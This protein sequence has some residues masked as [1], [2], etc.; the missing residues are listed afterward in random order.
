MV[1]GSNPWAYAYAGHQFGSFAGQLGDGRAISLGE[2]VNTRGRR[3]E[4]QLK[5]AGMTPYSRFADGYA[6]LRS[7]IREFLCSEAMFHLGI[8]TT[9]A[10]ALIGS[11]RIVQREQD[12]SGAIVCRL[13]PSWIRLG[14]FE[15]FY[16]TGDSENLQ[17]LADYAIT[18]HFPE[19]QPPDGSVDGPQTGKY[20][21]LLER[22]VAKTAE[23][24]AHWQAYGVM[25]TDNFSILGLTIDYGPFQFLDG[26]DPDYV[27]NKSDFTGMY[28][29]SEQPEVGLRNMVKFATAIS[30]LIIQECGG[31]REK[32][33]GELRPALNQYSSILSDRYGRLMAKKIGLATYKETDLQDVIYPLLTI[34]A[35]EAVDYTLFFRS[36]SQF[37]IAS[38]DALYPTEACSRT[39][40]TEPRLIIAQAKPS[41]GAALQPWLE[42]YRKRLLEDISGPDESCPLVTASREAE[43]RKQMDSIN[44]RYILR[45]HLAQTVIEAAEVGNYAEVNELLNVLSRPFEDGSIQEQ[46]RWGGAV[47]DWAAGVK[48][49][50]SS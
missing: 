32:A 42:I 39:G 37:S 18:M 46:E 23:M 50:C 31:D 19:I 1:P 14:N 40:P 34:I 17:K 38:T 3:W 15:L 22:V 10:L 29:F 20:T 49:S 6:V 35:K 8:P 44:P 26:Y 9:R 2:V 45:N 24:I 13:A 16:A 36:L 5:G 11:S 28:A 21:Q 30:P 33:S 47:P 4:L 27:C 7:S 43:R 25:N 41:L 12:E 48:C